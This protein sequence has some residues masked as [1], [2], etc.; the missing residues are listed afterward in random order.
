MQPILPWRPAVTLRDRDY[1]SRSDPANGI[2]MLGIERSPQL[3]RRKGLV[4]CALSPY[5]YRLK[6]VPMPWFKIDDSAHSH[7]KFIRAGN[8]ALGLW[9]RCGAY[10]A[11]HLLEGR[12]PKGIVKPFGGTAA[13]VR[14]LV[15]A[16]L[17]HAAEHDCPR[18][19]QPADG[20]YVMHDFLEAGRNSSKAQVEASRQAAADRAAKSR[21]RGAE[22]RGGKKRAGSARESNNIQYATSSEINSDRARN[23]PHFSGSTAGQGGLSQRTPLDSVTPSQA[24]PFKS[25]QAGGQEEAPLQSVQI[26]DWAQ[27]LIDALARR[28]ISV[29][30]AR[31]SSMQWIAIQE[32]MNKRGID[33]LVSVAA[34]RWNPRDPIKFASLLLT[35]WLEYPDPSAGSQVQRTSRQSELPEWCKHPDCDEISRTRET[36]DARGLRSAVPCSDCSPKAKGQA[37]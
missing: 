19:P 33:S 8:A 28:S 6:E 2:L 21:A 9:M 15:E 16:D 35:I 22:S 17:W 23:E 36:E 1:R 29:S 10:S 27:P 26:P 12:V 37:A 31:L 30:W 14:K 24:M 4:P 32:L 34:S 25:L 20:D 13:Q 5:P 18:C 11:Q 3:A 7:P